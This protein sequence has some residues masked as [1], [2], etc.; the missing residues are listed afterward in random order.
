[1]TFV[2]YDVNTTA[3]QLPTPN[4]PVS[5]LSSR[6]YQLYQHYVSAVSPTFTAQIYLGWGVQ[7]TTIQENAQTR[8]FLL[9]GILA[10]AAVHLA[11]SSHDQR[12]EYIQTAM[13]HQNRALREYRPVVSAG[14]QPA[15]YESALGFTALLVVSAFGLQSALFKHSIETLEIQHADPIVEIRNIITLFQGMTHIYQVGYFGSSDLRLTPA[16]SD[17]VD[18]NNSFPY[19][20]PG[21]ASLDLLE[22]DFLE[23]DYQRAHIDMM[24]AT[25]WDFSAPNE[26]GTN[27][28]AMKEDM[29]L[30]ESRLESPTDVYVYLIR[31]LRK[32]LR[33]TVTAPNIASYAFTWASC[34]PRAFSAALAVHRPLALVLVAHWAV[35]LHYL[36]DQWWADDWGIRLVATVARALGTEWRKYILWPL[37]EVGL[38]QDEFWSG[39]IVLQGL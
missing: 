16:L 38:E 27:H 9:S 23:F 5:S 8:P 29:L 37:R 13:R 21:E 22:R 17:H 34:T 1:M 36:R 2:S 24:E 14:L 35:S 6:D 19:P 31:R 11:L 15:D 7:D 18:H 28:P 26:I 30:P 10:T 33:K 12:A 4:W 20:G 3:W 32:V 39:S 25:D